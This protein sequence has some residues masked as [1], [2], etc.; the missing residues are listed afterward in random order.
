MIEIIVVRRNIW[1]YSRVAFIMS[2]KKKNV[3]EVNDSDYL[4]KVEWL[5][6]LQTKFVRQWLSSQHS[7]WTSPKSGPP[8]GPQVKPA[9]TKPCPSTTMKQMN[10]IFILVTRK[11]KWLR[12][13]A[14]TLFICS[15]KTSRY[16]T[17][18]RGP[19]KIVGKV[20]WNTGLNKKQV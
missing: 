18:R 7:L 4:L 17:W 3:L 16:N 14:P 8:F 9:L 10:A 11:R 13:L 6:Y 5:T 2:E 20:A 19:T 12:L 1:G 15:T